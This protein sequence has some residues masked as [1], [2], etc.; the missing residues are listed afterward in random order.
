MAERLGRSEL[1]FASGWKGCVICIRGSLGRG[2]GRTDMFA[3]Q[4]TFMKVK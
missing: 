3:L 1:A 2:D 4:V